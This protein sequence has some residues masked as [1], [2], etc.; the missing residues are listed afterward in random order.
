MVLCF[1]PLLFFECVEEG[2][3][4]LK[5]KKC[6]RRER[7]ELVFS[8]LLLLLLLLLLFLSFF[9]WAPHCSLTH[10]PF[11][12][13]TGKWVLELQQESPPLLLLLVT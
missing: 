12:A 10:G 7:G 2:G 9:P 1:P 3:G 5:E 13:T 6:E 8:L 11:R 4:E